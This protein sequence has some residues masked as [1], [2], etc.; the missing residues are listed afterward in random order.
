MHC[1]NEKRP[2]GRFFCVLPV[3]APAG[4]PEGWIQPIFHEMRTQMKSSMEK[5]TRNASAL[6]MFPLGRCMPS[7]LGGPPRIMYTKAMTRLAN[8]ATNANATKSFMI[9][10]IQ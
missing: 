4:M 1:F 10:I 3:H 8:M 7:G 6:A 5:P 9:G 2:N